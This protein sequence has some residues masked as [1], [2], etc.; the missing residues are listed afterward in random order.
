M[1]PDHY[2]SPNGFSFRLKFDGGEGFGNKKLISLN[3]RS[4]DFNSDMLSNILF[5]ELAGGI[6]LIM[7]YI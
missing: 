7:I 2:R 5:S 3:P 1:N 4:R 6:K